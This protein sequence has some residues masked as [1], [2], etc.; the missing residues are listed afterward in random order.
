MIEIKQFNN[1][2]KGYFIAYEDDKAAGKMTYTYAGEAGIIIDHT[3]VNPEFKGKNIGKML[4]MNAVD[5]A[6]KNNKKIIPLCPFT[7]SVFDKTES[8]RDVLA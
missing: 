8:I 6:R 4:V 7:K 5:Y 2:H 3:E 1:D